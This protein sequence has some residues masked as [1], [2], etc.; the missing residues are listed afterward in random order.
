M[1]VPGRPVSSVS[2]L[3]LHKSDMRLLHLAAKLGPIITEAAQQVAAAMDQEEA[4]G[5]D[6]EETFQAGCYG[7]LMSPCS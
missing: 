6:Q 4:A 3:S 5:H 1:V 7:L 2:I